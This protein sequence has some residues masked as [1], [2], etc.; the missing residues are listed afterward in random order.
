MIANFVGDVL[1]AED[2]SLERFV[3]ELTEE[4]KKTFGYFIRDFINWIKGIFGKTDEVRMLEKKYAELF[5]SEKRVEVAT[6]SESGAKYSLSVNAKTELHKALYDKN[7]LGDILLRDET[8]PI[9]LERP[10]VKNKKMA[11]K[12]SHVRENVFTEA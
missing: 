5:G 1:F 3:N 10:N 12:I 4:K 11:M 8:P 2:N 6:K 9:M 7:Y